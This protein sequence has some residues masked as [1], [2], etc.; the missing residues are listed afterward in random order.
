MAPLTS[1]SATG[2]CALPVKVAQGRPATV[3]GVRVAPPSIDRRTVT[4]PVQL[5]DRVTQIGRCGWGANG[6][7][8]PDWAA[9]PT[10]GVLLA[11]A[12]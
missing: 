10:S 8:A 12:F 11:G 6:P 4:L 2:S 3:S 7:A 9:V 5:P 1:S